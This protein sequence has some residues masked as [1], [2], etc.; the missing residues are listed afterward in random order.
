VEEKFKEYQSFMEFTEDTVVMNNFGG[1]Y[2]VTFECC[3]CGKKTFLFEPFINIDLQLGSPGGIV[4]SVQDI[5]LE[6]FHEELIKGF[7][8]SSCR[9]T[10]KA[11]KVNKI[12][13][14]IRDQVS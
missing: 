4:K 6:S 9:D 10:K 12:L 7:Y 1:V 3:A 13:V 11:I 8:C 5:L 14:I 2:L